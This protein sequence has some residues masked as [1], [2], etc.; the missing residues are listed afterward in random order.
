M[1]CI[2]SRKRIAAIEAMEAQLA[3]SK[4]QLLDLL[5]QI[6]VKPDDMIWLDYPGHTKTSIFDVNEGNHHESLVVNPQ[7]L[8]DELKELRKE[9]KS[10]MEE[11]ELLK[12][13]AAYFAARKPVKYVFMK[14]Y[15]EAFSLSLICWVFRVSS[16]E[17]VDDRRR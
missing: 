5:A 6:E 15:Q 3:A 9:N 1:N 7:H 2:I 17:M 14:A 11:G 8:Y 16:S 4:R 13:V 12:W 10:L